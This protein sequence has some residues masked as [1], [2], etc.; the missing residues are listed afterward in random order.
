MIAIALAAGSGCGSTRID[1][2]RV[3]PDSPGSM[4]ESGR[5]RVYVNSI[6]HLYTS[7]QYRQL[8]A[9]ASSEEFP[10]HNYYHRL[11]ASIARNDTAA[12]SNAYEWI[13]LRIGQYEQRPGGPE[14]D[15]VLNNAAWQYV[16]DAYGVWEQFT[17][18][19]PQL[20]RLYAND[21]LASIPND[22]VLFGGTDPGRFALSGFNDVVGTNGLLIVT[23][24]ALADYMYMDYIRRR[25]GDRLSLPAQSDS[26]KAFQIYAEEVQAG[27]RPKNAQLDIEN[28]R[29]SVAG[30][31]GVMEINGILARMIF[32]RN[33]HDRQFFVEESYAIPWMY[34]Y[35]T[36]HGLIFRLNSEP[37]PISDA[38][39]AA[40]HEFW[41][42][43]EQKL[44]T[45]TAFSTDIAARKTYAKLRL[46]GGGLYA[47]RDRFDDAEKAFRQALRLF[48]EN[49]EA[50]YRLVKEVLLRQNRFD[51]AMRV[52]NEYRERLPAMVEQSA[53]VGASIELQSEQRRLDAMIEWIKSLEAKHGAEQR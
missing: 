26:R 41:A 49:Q 18:W 22:A 10:I 43:Y 42:H 53:R 12:V 30:V 38:M 1:E 28:G 40:D 46:A 9:A 39:A 21:I 24:N 29:V 45:I 25:Y 20:L 51:D 2:K 35:L 33:K 47:A 7:Q 52:M 32:D 48:P 3:Q 14:P 15:P 37:T 27:K 36:P 11:F 6:M 44:R 13:R 19:T 4:E 34:P 17:L 8:D 16:L 5:D 50:H 23:Q 31:L